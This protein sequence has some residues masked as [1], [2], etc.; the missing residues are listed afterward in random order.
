MTGPAATT[1]L[2]AQ[3]FDLLGDEY[4]QIVYCRDA[5]VGL[6]AIVAVH[7]TV[8]GP[9]M[10][11]TRFL[12]YGSETEGLV[13][14]LRLS[15]GMTYKQAVAG[16]D[17]GGGKAVIFG[18]PATVRTE[19][20]MRS[21][22]R[23]L[24]RLGGVYLTAEDVGTTQADMDLLREETPYVTG[25]S[26]HLGGSGDPSPA[27]A[28]GVLHAHHAVAA[29]L[30]GER[31]LDGR[32]VVVSGVGKVGAALARHLVD[33]GAKVTVADVRAEAIAPLVR[34]LG[35]QV[36]EPAAAHQVPCDIWA[37][38][39]LGAVL[40]EAS[41]PA[42]QCAAVCGAA[43]NQLATDGDAARVAARGVLYVPDFVANAGGVI[44]ISEEPPGYDA[45]RAMA[46]V[47]QIEGTVTRVL[48]RADA[49]GVTTAAAAD[50]LA[51]E[52]LA[53]AKAAR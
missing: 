49:D 29:R 3:V 17:Y 47:A 18:E 12:P 26:L 35:V 45:D 31:S 34:E 36:V 52:R 23:F 27:T 41:I 42:L 44:N 24:D 7:S 39:A 20:L 21:Y 19:A 48:E 46:H 51:E 4:E 32:H 9:A 15:R 43:N 40:N 16:I 53:A 30:W 50:R 28:W 22:G 37:P 13:D 5:D 33:A 14:V 10:G 2:R 25:T 6:R 8:L 11:G 38:C 1:D